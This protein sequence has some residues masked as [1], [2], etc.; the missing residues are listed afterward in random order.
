MMHGLDTETLDMT[1]AAISDFAGRELDDERLIELDE[2]DEYPA[3]LIRRMCSDELGIQ[4]LFIAEEHGGMGGSAYDVY[5]VCER[6][7]RID[8]G[9]ATSVLAT[10]LGSDPIL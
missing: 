10:F 6:M 5:R 2:A 3:E 4:L 1:L 9:V 7:A 8:L